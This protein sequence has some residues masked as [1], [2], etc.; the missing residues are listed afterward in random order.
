MTAYLSAVCAKPHWPFT[1]SPR[2]SDNLSCVLNSFGGFGHALSN[3]AIVAVCGFAILSA[4][5]I[6]PCYHSISRMTVCWQAIKYK[7]PESKP[8][9][10]S[11]DLRPWSS[12]TM[13]VTKFETYVSWSFLFTVFPGK[14]ENLDI[15]LIYVVLECKWK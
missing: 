6:R 11:H 7:M 12:F 15:K 8:Q 9:L 10:P 3:I 14:I 5:E 13:L 2:V 1:F 4:A